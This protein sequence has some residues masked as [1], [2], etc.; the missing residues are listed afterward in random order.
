[1]KEIFKADNVP[2]EWEQVDVS[3]MESGSKHSEELF[4][5]S[6]A[7]L[8][9]NKLGLKGKY[10]FFFQIANPFHLHTILICS[11]VSSTLPSNV[12]GTNLSM[13][14]SAK[15]S[16]STPPSC[17]SRTSPVTKPDTRV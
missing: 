10:I 14:L 13:S 6:I 15:N 7:S 16:T 4:R 5:E 11:Q 17:L 1:M 12:Q 2:I 3:G 8:K 9:R